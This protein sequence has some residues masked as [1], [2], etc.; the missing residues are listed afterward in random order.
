M[1]TVEW[2]RKTPINCTSPVHPVE[3]PLRFTYTVYDRHGYTVKFWTG[4][5]HPTP[6]CRGRTTPAGAK[7]KSEHARRSQRSLQ[8]ALCGLPSVVNSSC[9][10]PQMSREF[11]GRVRDVKVGRKHKL[12]AQIHDGGLTVVG[13][14]S[15]CHYIW[16]AFRALCISSR[17]NSVSEP[18]NAR[19]TRAPPEDCCL[20]LGFSR[21]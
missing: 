4:A 7:E 10:M 21:P 5:G 19:S 12:P 9:N 18:L 1:A 3:P 2:V 16:R 13:V 17:T 15:S 8:S 20:R 11:G 14:L 6:S